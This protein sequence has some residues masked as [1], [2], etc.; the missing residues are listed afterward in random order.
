[1]SVQNVHGMV[2][3]MALSVDTLSFVLYVA[4]KRQRNVLFCLFMEFLEK[5]W[6]RRRR[7]RRQRW[8]RR[9]QR[10]RRRRRWKA[11]QYRVGDVLFVPLSFITIHNTAQAK[12]VHKS[13]FYGREG[14][15]KNH[16][17]DYMCDD[18]CCARQPCRTATIAAAATA[19]AAAMST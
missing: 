12:C 8:R 15:H 14:N 2:D 10:R 9:R 11:K 19:A 3:D 13:K 17:P 7:R 5:R 18:A 16:T 6:H 4:W 1:M